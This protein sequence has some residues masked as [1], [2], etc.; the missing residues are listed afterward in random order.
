MPSQAQIEQFKRL[1][2]AQQEMLAR[3]MGIN[4]S[5]IDKLIAG[6][7]NKNEPPKPQVDLVERDVDEQAIT[8][9]LARQSSAQEQAEK[10]KPFGYQ[11][12]NRSA[13]SFAPASNI[14]V[15]SDYVL[16]PGDS[17]NV[18]L[19]GKTSEQFEL[20]V[21]NEGS[22]EIP[23][24]GPMTVTGT[25]YQEFKQ[26]LSQRY[27]EQMIGVTPH[28]TMG[29]L[30]TIQVFMVGEAFRPGSLTVSSLSTLT[31]A[32]FASGG[33]SKIGTLRN[34]QL[35]RAG[36]TVA[37]FDLYELLVNGDTTNDIR[38]QQGDVIFIPPVSKV[39][40]VDGLVRRPAIYEL[41]QGESLAELLNI[42]G[43][44]LPAAASTLQI[45]R[46]DQTSGF[47]IESV[48]LGETLS[49]VKL[50]NG[51]FINVPEAGREFS[52]ALLVVG[53]VKTPGIKQFQAG[54][55]LSDVVSPDS[56]MASVDTEYGLIIRRG[57]FERHSEVIQF[58]PKALFSG[59]YDV[60]LSAR[61]KILLFN[62]FESVADNS[63]SDTGKVGT[64]TENAPAAKSNP[65]QSG[66]DRQSLLFS[67]EQND[68]TESNYL[69]T[70]ENSVFTEQ[71]LVLQETQKMSRDK[72][73]APVV[74]LLR[75]EAD[76]KRPARLAEINGDVKFPGIYP[77]PS[78]SDVASLIK[79]AGGL[80][81][82]AY[83][84]RAEVTR[85][86]LN[87]ESVTIQHLSFDP[88]KALSGVESAMSVEPKDKINILRMPDWH[89]SNQVELVGEFV[90]PGV[91]Q[92]RKGETLSQ[93]IA[94]AG[95]VTDKASVEAAIFTREELRKKEQNNI[96]RAVQELRE[97]IIN[98]NLKS[99][100]F[101]QAVD[102]DQAQKILKDLTN[103]KSVGR[104]VIDF[105]G[106]V[107]ENAKADIELKDGDKIYL[108]NITPAVSVIGEVFVPSTHSYSIGMSIEDYVR[109]SGGLK[110]YG[111]KDRIYVVKADGSVHIPG[112]N[113]W[114]SSDGKK[115]LSPGDTIVVPRDVTNY[116]QLGLWQAVTQ[117]AYQAAVALAAI[118]S[119]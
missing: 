59:Q 87:G 106:I 37:D 64:Q 28:I 24:L 98:S 83:A 65:I 74:A 36:K 112:N 69:L 7:S 101:V 88:T 84:K 56:V 80:R 30:R 5:D 86:V 42:A 46:S 104:L 23:E 94:R 49:A 20:V 118:K 110:T 39:V 70:I 9:A 17:V 99:S 91:Y 51:D 47:S 82:S 109:L 35:K 58:S 1:P 33:V 93:L 113:F 22:V 27:A 85:T 105:K 14:A 116:E 13:E 81:E 90:F 62:E 29:Q 45:A 54:M 75:A 111:D 31:N 114:F 11:L 40:S 97:Q 63:M 16:G 78:G 72:L 100:Q 89:E 57:K 44:L 48:S 92:I 119:F 66:N 12:F 50:L 18:R 26:Q 38:L 60:N 4:L 3:Q 2:R 108:P 95:G 8:T 79:A 115:Q 19:F 61:D 34:I 107:A 68:I 6:T 117:I 21:N 102:Y 71:Q 55:R 77:I 25:T 32:L 15:P 43:G 96:D 52:N 73:L 67:N 76:D 53:A 10:L 103:V 41:K